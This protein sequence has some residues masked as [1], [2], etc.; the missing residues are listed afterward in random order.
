[1]NHWYVLTLKLTQFRFNFVGSKAF[2]HL[3]FFDIAFC[4]CVWKPSSRFLFI[5]FFI[6][7]AEKKQNKQIS[8]KY[9]NIHK[10]LHIE[11]LRKTKKHTKGRWNVNFYYT[12]TLSRWEKSHAHTHTYTTQK[13]P[14]NNAPPAKTVNKQRISNTSQTLFNCLWFHSLFNWISLIYSFIIHCKC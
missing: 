10:L 2:N 14:H 3:I 9:K 1:M 13:P 7:F 5:Y 4:L 11:I 6:N 8:L 12:H